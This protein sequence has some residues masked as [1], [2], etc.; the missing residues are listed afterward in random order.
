MLALQYYIVEEFKEHKIFLRIVTAE[1]VKAL[2]KPE[3]MC[4]VE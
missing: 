2:L 4:F 3:D 1:M